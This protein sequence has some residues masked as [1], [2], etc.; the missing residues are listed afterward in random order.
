MQSL[1]LAVL[2]LLSQRLKRSFGALGLD[3]KLRTLVYINTNQDKFQETIHDL[4]KVSNCRL[5]QS[6]ENDKDSDIRKITYIKLQF[7]DSKTQAVDLEI[8]KMKQN[9]AYYDEENMAKKMVQSINA[10]SS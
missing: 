7:H 2:F 8:Y 4:S 3:I 1:R 10:L 5:H 9:L 6:E